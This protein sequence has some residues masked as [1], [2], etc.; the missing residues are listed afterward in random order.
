[1]TVNSTSSSYS[2]SAYKKTPQ[3]GLFKVPTRTEKAEI[4]RLEG[5]YNSHL[6]ARGTAYHNSKAESQAYQNY[7]NSFPTDN[8]YSRPLSSIPSSP[9]D[10][11]SSRPA[12]T[13]SYRTREEED[14]ATRP[15]IPYPSFSR[16]HSKEIPTPAQ[17]MWNG[18][19]LDDS[20]PSITK[21]PRNQRKSSLLT[22][23]SPPRQHVSRSSTT[24]LTTTDREERSSFHRPR[25]TQTWHSTPSNSRHVRR[26]EHSTTSSSQLRAISEER[27]GD[28]GGRRKRSRERRHKH[29]Y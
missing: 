9:N 28:D 6:A 24:P 18:L 23:T 21:K 3:F 13:Q 29:E 16:D 14:A 20:L 19:P 27:S 10:L 12:P 2:S 8:T 5:I 4:D 7:L 17:R 22:S 25:Q 1:M 11:F 15:S 26:G